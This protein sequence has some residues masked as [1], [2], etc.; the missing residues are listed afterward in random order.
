[1]KTKVFALSVAALFLVGTYACSLKEVDKAVDT[2]DKAAGLAEKFEDKAEEKKGSSEGGETAQ[3]AGGVR[4]QSGVRID[5]Y[6]PNEDLLSPTQVELPA[7]IKATI[8]PAGDIDFYK[9]HVASNKREL[10]NVTLL[11]P[12]TN[13]RPCLHFYNQNRERFGGT[14][15]VQPGTAK[16]GGEIIALPNQDYYVAACTSS[17]G[18]CACR[19]SGGNS[20]KYYTL[21]IELAGVGDKYEPNESLTEA[22][23]VSPGKI[24]GTINPKNDKD[25][26]KVRFSR[27]GTV[28]VTFHNPTLNLQ[29]CLH[30]YDQNRQQFGQTSRVQ[31]GAAKTGGKFN[32]QPNQDYYVK[33]CTSS[34][35]NCACRG[36]GGNSE[37]PYTLEIR[38]VE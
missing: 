25:V 21:K 4:Q 17:S 10:V 27:S 15:R 30:F 7:T 8:E 13:L 11:N 1:M 3:A 24:K 28:K 33:V 32:V 34:S 19:E 31:A 22:T 9:F 20:S 18:N 2:A 5:K 29:P 16:V 14:G 36:S 12:T 35:G 6:E 26:Y 37:K 38:M 23:T